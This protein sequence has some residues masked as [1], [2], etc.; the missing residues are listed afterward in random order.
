MLTESDADDQACGAHP[1]SRRKVEPEGGSLPHLG[2]QGA[3]AVPP[4]TPERDNDVRGPRRPQCIDQAGAIPV[5]TLDAARTRAQARLGDFAKTGEHPR[6]R[7]IV[8]LADLL[9]DRYTSWFNAEHKNGQRN[10]DAIES[11]F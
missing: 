4:D 10:I 8:T 5:V 6:K 7:K 11:Q 9:R 3:R 2:R 1:S